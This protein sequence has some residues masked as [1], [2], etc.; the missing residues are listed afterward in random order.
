MII[1][2]RNISA[3]PLAEHGDQVDVK[4]YRVGRSEVL[5]GI[6]TDFGHVQTPDGDVPFSPGDY[7]V[8]DLPP[9]HAWPV[10]QEVFEATH[11]EA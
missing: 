11:V 8:S 3:H 6:A 2:G 1:D 7:I 10:G 5:A 9:T 4:R